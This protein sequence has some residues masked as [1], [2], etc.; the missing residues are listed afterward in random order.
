[1]RISKSSQLP[2]VVRDVSDDE[3]R[4]LDHPLVAANDGKPWRH[5][6]E[7][8]IDDLIEEA[9]LLFEFLLQGSREIGNNEAVSDILRCFLRI[10]HASGS[11]A[12]ER[13]VSARVAD[14]RL[15]ALGKIKQLS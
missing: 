2:E 9:F 3:I 11:E 13:A 10:L 4:L 7:R 5:V 8:R 14:E 6:L 12:V 15:V 1:M